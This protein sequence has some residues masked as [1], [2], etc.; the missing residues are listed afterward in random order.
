MNNLVFAKAMQSYIRKHRDVKLVT[1]ESGRIYLVSDLTYD[2][3]KVSHRTSI[4]KTNET[5]Q[6]YL[7]MHL[8]I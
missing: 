2:T 3:T 5:K 7:W 1:T 8:S 6:R 4:N